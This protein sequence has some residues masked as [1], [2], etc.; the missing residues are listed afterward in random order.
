MHIT[1]IAS[2]LPFALYVAGTL[3]ELAPLAWLGA[4]AVG[5]PW[6]AYGDSREALVLDALA[7]GFAAWS[8]ARSRPVAVRL[9]V[10]AMA[11]TLYVGS[12]RVSSQ[13][14]RTQL[15]P[16]EPPSAVAARFDPHLASTRYALETR[17]MA[18]LHD[19]SLRTVGQRLPI[20]LGLIAVVALAPLALGRRRNAPQT[21]AGSL[22]S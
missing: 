22:Q 18:D 19:A 13:L 3:P 12:G 17:T 4:L 11:L 6:P 7:L 20:W 2:A 15:R 14:P 16:A 21:P 10:A 5:L 9:G 8:V 1:E